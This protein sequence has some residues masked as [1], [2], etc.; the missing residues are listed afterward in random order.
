MYLAAH[1][2]AH[3]TNGGMFGFGLALI[4]IGLFWPKKK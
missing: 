4:A 1:H 3:H 2:A